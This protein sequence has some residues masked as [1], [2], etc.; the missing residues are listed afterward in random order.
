MTDEEEQE[1]INQEKKQEEIKEQNSA[2]E[3]EVKSQSMID[4][5]NAAADRIEKANKTLSTSIAKMERM[6]T[7]EMLGGETETGHKKET[8]EEKEDEKARK[9]LKGT[10]YEDLLFPKAK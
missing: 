6:K 9:M 10:G 3:D 2:Q 5:A 4:K 7:E 8:D 1:K